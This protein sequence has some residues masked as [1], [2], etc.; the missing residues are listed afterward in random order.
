MSEVRQSGYSKE[1]THD[2]VTP[3]D[4]LPLR[5]ILSCLR[6]HPAT[7]GFDAARSTVITTSACLCKY[8]VS[9]RPTSIRKGSEICPGHKQERQEC[10]EEELRRATTPASISIEWVIKYA[11]CRSCPYIVLTCLVVGIAGHG[12]DREA[13]TSSL[14][15][16]V[17]QRDVSWSDGDVDDEARCLLHLGFWTTDLDLT[18]QGWTT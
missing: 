3:S 5:R 1:C 12:D 10:D 4:L 8:N 11:L 2:L 13:V 15:C 16:P 9:L 7:G 6:V 17:L 14:S 18:D